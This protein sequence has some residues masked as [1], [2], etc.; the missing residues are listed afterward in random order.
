M[1]L[2]D[3]E[4]HVR[5]MFKAGT[6]AVSLTFLAAAGIAGPAAAVGAEMPSHA[7]SAAETVSA[8]NRSPATYTNPLSLA[9]PDG[10]QAESCADP[11]TMHGAKRG[12]T[13]WYLY[14]TSDAL[15]SSEHSADGSL[16]I[17]NLPT[18]RS[19]DLV[20]WTYT[21]D[22]FAT[23]PSWVK[24]DAGMWAPDVVYLNG[25][26]LL[27]YAAS[28]TNLPGGGSAVGVATS[29]SPTG[30]WVDSG[31]PVVEPKDSAGVPASKRWEFD[32]E[33]ISAAGKSYI[34]FGSYFGGIFA[35][36]L[37]ADGLTSDPASETQIAIDNRYEGTFIVKHDGWYY[38]MGSATNCC[39]GPLTGYSV[40]AARSRSPLG[41]FVDRDGVSILSS[42]VGGTPVLAQNGNRWV[43][44]GHN[45]VIT[46]FAGQDW[47]VY[48]AV[49]RNHPYYAGDATYTKRPGLIDPLDW[50]GGWPTVR[51]GRGPSDTVMPAPVAQ[52]GQR[53]GYR[54]DPLVEPRPGRTIDALSDGFGRAALSPQWSWIRPPDASTYSVQNGALAW[55]TQD[56]DIHPPAAPL[57]SVLAEP[58]PSGDYVVETRV[59]VNT[60]P[61]G[62]G[63]NYVQGGLVIYGDDGDYVKLASVSIWNTRQTEF[64]KEVT[65]AGTSSYGNGVVGPVGDWTTLRIVHHVVEGED[66]YTA[67][68]SLDGVHWDKGDTWTADLGAHPK[69]G[70]ISMGGS[71]YVST[72]DYVRVSR[73]AGH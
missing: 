22:A 14:C 11:F 26:Y 12:D 4:F 66:A 8:T 27:Y 37:S 25:K 60:P 63:K 13:N 61:S 50:Q 52:P 17:H 53:A 69:I 70:L 32:P 57:A 30:P 15:T 23:K 35:R 68:T 56:A 18:Y 71:G 40:F 55:Q 36:Q 42:R 47:I 6:I 67:Y 46:D 65:V 49:D 29:S 7:A 44:A 21:G 34:Y 43:G 48:H 59:S 5:T 19:T 45:A 10:T 73:V 24:A 9:L 51:G 72:F 1:H 20:H 62:M 3:E 33:V 41:P 54:A 2:D 64:G 16:V 58:A 28:D 39:A 31:A 38:F